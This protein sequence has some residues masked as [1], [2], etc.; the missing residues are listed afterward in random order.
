MHSSTTSLGT[1]AAGNS[2]SMASA[3]VG[4]VGGS[5][6]G[7]KGQHARFA[8]VR[9]GAFPDTLSSRPSRPVHAPWPTLR[10]TGRLRR[11]APPPPVN[12]TLGAAP[13]TFPKIHCKD[14]SY[15]SGFVEVNPEIHDDHIN[16]EIW[17]IASDR[18]SMIVD[19]SS[20][21]DEDVAAVTE[22]ELNVSQTKELIRQLQLAV[23]KLEAK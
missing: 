19:E 13:W 7:G 12:S 21:T 20:L 22:I 14:I 23:S 9:A 2:A 3:G 5:Q 8:P 10:S 17:N 15:R 6:F 4:A 16:L 11:C 18:A 1:W